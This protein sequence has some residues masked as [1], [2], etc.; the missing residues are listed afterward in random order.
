MQ[1]RCI[2]RIH[3]I[4][5]EFA[6]KYIDEDIPTLMASGTSGHNMDVFQ[7]YDRPN[8]GGLGDQ[9]GLYMTPQKGKLICVN[10][11]QIYCFPRSTI[12]MSVLS[13]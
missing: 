4:Y 8:D 7:T 13:L 12:T 11:V 1:L 2:A 10:L 5:E 6:E 9:N 3:D